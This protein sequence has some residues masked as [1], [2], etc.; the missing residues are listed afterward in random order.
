MRVAHFVQRYPPALGG[1]EAY[2][3]RLSRHLV[4]NGDQVSVFTTN[5]NDLEAFWSTRGRRF[6]AGTS[7]E[8]GVEVRRYPLWRI[9]GHRRM[10]KVLSFLPVRPWQRLTM[11]CNPIAWGMARDAL[12]GTEHFDVVHASAFPYGWI[13]ECARRLVELEQLCHPQT[14]RAACCS[15]RTPSSRSDTGTR[16]SA[17]WMS[18]DASSVSIRAGKNP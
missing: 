7:T 3:A 9:P 13:L 8:Q 1:S 10:L 6:R 12:R 11:S 4:A 18:R 2:F 5:A 14:A 17:E 15:Q 16:S